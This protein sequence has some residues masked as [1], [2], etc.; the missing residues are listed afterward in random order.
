MV[1][2]AG[3]A[4]YGRGTGGERDA[5]RT[6]RTP[7]VLP[8]APLLRESCM[9]VTRGPH[10][11]IGMAQ[12]A[13]QLTGPATNAVDMGP[14]TSLRSRFSSIY[15]PPIPVCTASGHPVPIVHR[16]ELTFPQ[17]WDQRCRSTRRGV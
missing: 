8:R 15:S 13:F 7:R 5:L 9:E 12:P 1:C 4:D 6:L 11:Q 2:C 17:H 10:K 16:P 3:R 14:V